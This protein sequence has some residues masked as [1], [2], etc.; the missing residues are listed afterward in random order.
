MKKI[1]LSIFA[2]V[3]TIGLVASTAYALF[4]DTVQVSGITISSGN[5]DL[6]IYA[7]GTTDPIE[8]SL[9]LVTLPPLYPGY[10]E[11]FKLDFKNNSTSSI[12]LNLTAKLTHAEGDWNSLKD[13]IMLAYSDTGTGDEPTS[14]WRTLDFWYTNGITIGTPLTKLEGIKTYKFFVKVL[15]FNNTFANKI[16]SNMSFEIT[17]TQAN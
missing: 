3:L 10:T 13:K 2:I 16:L 8:G 9:S 12:N 11:N 1:S 17:G 5:A 4:S 15:D 14:A 6:M 7:Y